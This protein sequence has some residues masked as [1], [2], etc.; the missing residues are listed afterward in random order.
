[1]KTLKTFSNWSGNLQFTP[2]SVNYPD[3]I[4]AIVALVDEARLASKRVRL[5]GSGHSWMPL[6]ET[7]DV[8]VSL[9]HWQGV[10][11]VDH[12]QQT[13]VVRAG[14]KLSRL[15]QELF[16]HGVALANMGD[17]DVQ[18]I[19]GAFFTGTHGT[20]TEHQI[21]SSQLV[22]VTLVT[23]DGQVLEWNEQDHPD[24][25]NAVR[26]SFGALGIVVKMEVKVQPAFKLEELQYRQPLDQV[27]S[28][29][30]TFKQSNRHFEFFWFPQ[31]ENVVIKRVNVTDRPVLKPKKY[32]VF[33][34]D[35]ALSR[36]LKLAARFPKMG[37]QIN[38]AVMALVDHETE[39]SADYAH[40]VFP[41]PRELRFN[42]MEYNIPAEHWKACFSEIVELY[43]QPGF[44][45]FFPIECRWVK[46]D[47]IWLSPAYQ[48]DSAYI[49]VHQVA[50]S[51]YEEAFAQIEAIFRKYDGRPHWGKLNTMSR[52][53]AWET[54]PKLKDFAELR[55]Q[56]D[57]Q[58]VFSNDYV[59]HMIGL[60]VP[61][62]A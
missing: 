22:A 25:M 16:E 14:T 10:E 15:G 6:I 46:G 49:A 29:L 20:G 60:G 44:N 12:D 47:D 11:A 48:R 59:S 13:A 2:Q 21:L 43:S 56:L 58:G 8:L 51:P 37:R 32:M 5:V 54:Y 24:E 34:E 7:E 53:E 42:E 50:G 19:A 62:T 36:A 45:V 40:L 35:R 38:Q 33:L 30:E 55:D 26:V 4:E 61:E 39:G 31:T 18:S 27:F 52:E 28:N 3:S 23:A 1:M 9:D 57:P 17:I 41:S